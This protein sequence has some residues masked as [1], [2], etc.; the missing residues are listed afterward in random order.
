MEAAESLELQG[1]RMEAVLAQEQ[2]GEA[3]QGEA[4]EGWQGQNGRNVPVHC[5]TSCHATRA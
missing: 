4:K 3:E 2:G 1:G 5:G